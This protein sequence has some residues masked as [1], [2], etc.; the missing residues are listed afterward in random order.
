MKPE[1]VERING[2]S[3]GGSAIGPDTGRTVSRRVHRNKSTR[4]GVSLPR[5]R[6]GRWDTVHL[7]HL[8]DLLSLDVLCAQPDLQPP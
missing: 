2:V 1:L 8:P 6:A 5:C 3:G 4:G 7:D